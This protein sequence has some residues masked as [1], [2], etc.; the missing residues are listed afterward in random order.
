MGSWTPPGDGQRELPG[1]EF[2]REG[3]PDSC[4]LN[5]TL[6]KHTH[7]SVFHHPQKG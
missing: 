1:R 5:H 7:V 3:V 4:W 2:C 6:A